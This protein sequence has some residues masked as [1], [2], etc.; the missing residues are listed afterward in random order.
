VAWLGQVGPAQG[1]PRRGES[2][3]GE[4]Q[5]EAERLRQ[6]TA[7]VREPS[8]N[9]TI[10]DTPAAVTITDDSGRS[11]TFHPTGKPESQTLDG[12]TVETITTREA[13]SLIVLYKVAPGRELRY[14]FS[15]VA[16]PAQL[17]ID[18]WFLERGGSDV[19]K[20]V[21]AASGANE[22]SA[23]TAS[24]VP[25]AR[26][27]SG[28]RVPGQPLNQQPD[29]ALKGLKKLGVVVEDLTPESSACG[30]HQGMIETAVAKNVSDAGFTVVRNTDED[31]YIYVNII[32]SSPSAGLC[33]SR[34]DVFL[35]T[36]TTAMLSYQN[37]PVLVQV[38]L[39]HKGGIAGGAPAAH[40][41]S[42]L[43]GTQA[44]VDQV[45]MRIRDANR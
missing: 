40:A 1:P 9:L 41:E 24:A 13:G 17:T 44:Y 25:A 43:R 28:D 22:T 33:V 37:V 5:E 42:V 7:E 29:A 30:L 32:T 45:A 8:V 20:R 36:H 16:A 26:S 39:W 14:T 15:R 18:V 35:Y 38:S 11:R 27:S 12:T 3:R 10:V 21:Y 4:S 2:Q 31:T 23:D 19:V 6:L 34:Y